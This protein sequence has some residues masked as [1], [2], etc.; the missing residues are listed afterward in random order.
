[1]R[2]G[3]EKAKNHQWFSTFFFNATARGQQKKVLGVSTIP[4]RT[5][6]LVQF[7]V[8]TTN[9]LAKQ[10]HR[11]QNT[12]GCEEDGERAQG[13]QI[14]NNIEI[15]SF[16]WISKLN[17]SWASADLQDHTHAPGLKQPWIQTSAVSHYYLLTRL[18]HGPGLDRPQARYHPASSSWVLTKTYPTAYPRDSPK[19]TRAGFLCHYSQHYR[20]CLLRAASQEAV[21]LERAK[22]KGCRYYQSCSPG[23][24]ADFTEVQCLKRGSVQKWSKRVAA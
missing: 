15:T 17:S 21:R 20:I 4:K 19:G 13:I 14:P 1:M 6:F 24:K 5:R 11:N 2:S 3:L 10:C 22:L 7:V 9:L 12:E 23:S 18:Q 8:K 16:S